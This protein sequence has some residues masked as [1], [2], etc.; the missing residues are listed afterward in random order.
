[1]YNIDIDK[2]MEYIQ[3]GRIVC[4]G[5]DDELKNDESSIFTTEINSSKFPVP[6][7]VL[8]SATTTI[9][10]V[11]FGVE[12][13][14]FTQRK[15]TKRFRFTLNSQFKNLKLTKQSKLVIESICLPNVMSNSF[16][17][18]K[19]CNNIILKMKGIPNNNLWDSST[20]GKGASIIFTSPI[21][22]NTQGYGVSSG[23]TDPT[24]LASSQYPRF[25]SDNNGRLFINPNPEYLYN[26]NITDEFLANGIFEFELIYDISNVWK[27]TA[28]PDE[29]L[30]VPQTLDYLQD[31]DDLE[32]FMISFVIV[33]TDY[34][35]KIYDEK[36]LLNT[37]NKLL[38]AKS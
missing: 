11:N 16:I 10:G 7:A 12:A 28:T 8:P 22:I 3:K 1:M 23:A 29:F 19:S 26:F 18:S 36:K 31:K 13:V 27:N 37:L 5:I 9:D 6:I 2:N 14:A 21:N 4:L 24:G 25:N 32:A 38:L 17:Q 35:N 33:D 34:E 30:Y 15:N 20:K